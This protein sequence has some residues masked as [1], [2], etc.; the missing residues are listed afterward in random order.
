MQIV[1]SIYY[2][3]HRR[4][5]LGAYCLRL[6]YRRVFYKGVCNTPL[7]AI[8]T[9]LSFMINKTYVDTYASG[10]G[11]YQKTSLAYYNRRVVSIAITNSIAII[12]HES[13]NLQNINCIFNKLTIT[14]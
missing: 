3:C 1:S 5:T 2:L 13:S 9:I 11:G 7:P 8:T 12:K 10:G 14:H 4:L 6:F